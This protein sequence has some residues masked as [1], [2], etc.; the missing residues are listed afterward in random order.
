MSSGRIVD[1]RRGKPEA[2]RESP[3]HRPQREERRSPLRRRRRRARLVIAFIVLLVLLA[4]VYG[5]HAASYA[6]PLTIQSVSVDGVQAIPPDIIETFVQSELNDGS[7][8]F[9]SRANIFLYPKKA[10]T[11]ALARNFPRVSAA[12]LSRDSLLSTHLTIT[13]TER[14]PYATWCKSSP[15]GTT[16]DTTQ[17]G[18]CFVMD[19][20]G[21]LFADATDST[22]HV[23]SNYIFTGGISSTSTPIGQTFAPA[24]LAGIAA[25]MKL[26]VNAG[27]TPQGAS[28]ENDQDFF[29][30]LQEG[31]FLKASYGEDAAQ[32]VHNLQLILSSDTLT[33][34]EADLDYIDLRFG[35]RVYYK[36]K[37]LAETQ[38][39]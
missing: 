17:P 23:G 11:A 3:Q 9:F 30:Q 35:N 29:I 2:R 38:V 20:R 39:Q 24:H 36:L 22:D 26:L 21:F 6:S 34:K 19:E 28:I 37:G 5:V 16:I 31:F 12:S 15:D 25:L 4:A 8:H 7:Y 27:F 32:L 18:E 33:G 13:I 14:Q 1:L 10:I